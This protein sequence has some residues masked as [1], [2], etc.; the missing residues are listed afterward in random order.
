MS[1]PEGIAIS[2]VIPTWRRTASLRACLG[3]ILSCDPRPVEILVHVD[4]GDD[5]TIPALRD[6]YGAAVRW[7]QSPVQ[8]GPGGG[9]NLLFGQARHEIVVSFDDDSWPLH[10]DF[11]ALARSLIGAHERVAVL[12]CKILYPGRL[13]GPDRRGSEP[14]SFEGCGA[15][16][17]R[18]AFLQTQGYVPLRYAYGMEEL[19]LTFQLRDLG[20]EVRCEDRLRVYHDTDL[21]H[22]R[23][24]ALNAAH[25]RN[26]WLLAFLRYPLSYWPLGM[27]QFL[28]RILYSIRR[29]RFAGI[30]RGV[31]TTMPEC[32]RQRHHRHPVRAATVRLARRLAR[33]GIGA[34]ETA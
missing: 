30:L 22:H 24:A 4:A 6:E 8:A 21:A 11:F 32:W 26:T 28:S 14:G 20:W 33:G 13:E 27:A 12:A 7:L 29:R 16:F 18:S 3:K 9:R 25:I 10:D 19:D 5:E 2:V 15:V 34:E 31:L 1:Q 17:R 23:H